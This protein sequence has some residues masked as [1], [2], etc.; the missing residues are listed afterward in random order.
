MEIRLEDPGLGEPAAVRAARAASRQRRRPQ[1]RLARRLQGPRHAVRRGRRHRSGDGRR[2][3]VPREL[4]RL[5]RRLRRLAAAL[6]RSVGWPRTTTRATD[7][8]VAL[9]AELAMDADGVAVLAL[10]FGRTSAEAGFHARAIAADAVRDDPQRLRRR[11]ALL[12][13]GPA[14]AG[15]AARAATTSIA[16]ARPSCTATRR[17]PFPAASSRASRFPGAS[18][19][20]TTTSAAIISSGRATSARPAGALLACGADT[21]VRRVLRYL[22]A[23]QEADGSWPQ[24]CWLDGS[25]Y[26]G[27]V[28]LDECAFPMLLLDMAWREGALRRPDLPALLADG[29]SARP[30]SSCATGRGPSRTAGRKTPAIRPSP[31]PSPIA[32]LLGGRRNRRGPGRST[33]RRRRSSATRPT[34]GTSRSRTGSMSTTRRSRARPASPAITSAS[35]RNRR[36]TAGPDPTGRSR[37]ATTRREPARSPADALVSTDALALVR[38]GLRAP[39]DPRILDT[40]TVIDK[41]LKVDLPQGPGWRR[42]NLDGYG[43]KAD[44]RPFDGVGIGRVLAAAGR[45]ARALRARRGAARRKPSAA[46]DDRGADQSG[47]AA[48]PSRSGTGRRSP[49]ANS[50]PASRPARRCRSSGR[51]R[52]MS[53]FCGRSRTARCSTCR[54]TRVRRYVRG[55]QRG[56]LPAMAAGLSRSPRF[57]PGRALRLDLPQASI[58]RYH[59]RRTGAP[60]RTSRPAIPGVGL[61]PAEIATDGMSAGRA[62]RLHLARQG[63]RRV[64]RTKLRGRDRGLGLALCAP[65]ATNR[66]TVARSGRSRSA[67]ARAPP[68]RPR[69]PSARRP[70]ERRRSGKASRNAD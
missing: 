9:T 35:R 19:R 10:G 4:G 20:A 13:G 44:G 34:P 11:L 37:C 59:A 33:T 67:A 51:M 23:T 42:Y 64:A 62:D 6:A 21:E 30:A 28:Q 29:R 24:N 52:N 58:V 18:A 1:H 65:A 25:A 39:D 54:R 41:L 63:D 14:L 55:K 49:R 26:W 56:P 3:A 61:F 68:A 5:R 47:R 8:N 16:S 15:A 31:S 40:V 38:F 43:E 69:R 45:R 36:T 66:G 7:G 50:R 48:S 12:A 32:A 46:R 53:S 70:P 57:P 17:R 2:P 27:G 60:R 22:R